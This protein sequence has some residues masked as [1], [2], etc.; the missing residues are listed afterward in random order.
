MD[1]DVNRAVALP[2]RWTPVEVG[3]F[4]RINE[5]TCVPFG[6]FSLTHYQIC[7]HSLRCLQ[8]CN[9]RYVIPAPVRVFTKH[10]VHDTFPSIKQCGEEGA[11]SKP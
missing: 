9:A 1:R 6:P 4:F 8:T 2:L 11:Q 7:S 10:D 5:V 3:I